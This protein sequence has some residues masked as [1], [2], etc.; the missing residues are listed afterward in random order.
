M[1]KSSAIGFRVVG[2]LVA[3]LS[4]VPSIACS[5]S[6]ADTK[7]KSSDD[8]DDKPKKKKRKAPKLPDDQ[9]DQKSIDGGMELLDSEKPVAFAGVAELQVPGGATRKIDALGDAGLVTYQYKTSRD[10]ALVGFLALLAENDWKVDEWKRLETGSAMFQIAKEGEKHQCIGGAP[11]GE[12]RT[13]GNLT[14][15]VPIKVLKKKYPIGLRFVSTPEKVKAPWSNDKA[16]WP[17][18]VTRIYGKLGFVEY[19]DGSKA[20]QKLDQM[21]PPQEA[22]LDPKD[23]CGFEVKDKVKAPY[24]T[25]QT[26]FGAKVK[27]IYGHFAFL[28]Y[29]DKNVMW[30]DCTA[31]KKP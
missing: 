26:L 28:E 27:E 5:K 15:F 19:N 24:A 7:K 18:K 6:D 25:N 21:E 30:A 23:D 4:L 20:W 2:F 13:A 10:K 29:D 1:N 31:M 22:D 11:K 8:E 14:C 16:P 17:G 12:E 3:S 9:F